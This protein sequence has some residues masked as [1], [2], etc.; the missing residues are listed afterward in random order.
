MDTLRICRQCRAPLPGDAPGMVCPQCEKTPTGIL[1]FQTPPAPEAPPPTA[2]E[3]APFFPQ[4]E[5]IELQGHGGM[6]MV[7]KARQ[8]KLDRLVAIKILAPELSH[9]PAFAERFE[10]EA[11]ALGRL[12]HSNIIAIYDFGRAG[13]FYYFLMEFVD[14]V[15]LYDLIHDK[16]ISLGDTL[17]ITGEI[18]DALQFAHDEGVVHRDIKP[19]NILIDKKGRVKIADFG[20]AKLGGQSGRARS[21]GLQTTFVMG[22]PHYMAPEQ[23]ETPLEVDHRADIYSLGVVVYE[24]LTGEL[25][26]GR[27]AAPSQKTRLDARLDQVVLRALEKEPSRRYQQARQIRT[28]IETVCGPTA[29][30][31]ANSTPANIMS[32]KAVLWRQTALMMAAALLAVFIYKTWRF[33]RPPGAPARGAP[34]RVAGTPPP[35]PELFD[36][37]RDG[38]TLS[39][40]AISSLHLARAQARQ[41]NQIIGD[42]EKEFVDLEQRH[43]EQ[44]TDA[45]GHVHLT[46]KS[47]PQ[48]M[49]NLTD[50]M[51]EHLGLVLA[52]S[53][54]AT[55]RNIHLERLFGNS[56]KNTSAIELWK[57]NGQYHFVDSQDG[58]GDSSKATSRAVSGPSPRIIPKR[59]RMYLREDAAANGQ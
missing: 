56:G 41:V 43:T 52:P 49:R 27:F 17:R 2:G 47:F 5:V 34:A 54:L 44:F 30:M 9:D 58:G 35:A 37:G 38:S 22:T 48:P 59:F 11:K 42:L 21:G 12:N 57:E 24:M 53:Q 33:H 40:H 3:I 18:C 29:V 55:A 4:L 51:W 36:R 28:E 8:P 7:Y 10:R 32:R 14:G 31:A 20:L 39:E 45:A 50:Q 1:A 23:V 26:L 6:G 15:S 13:P 16:Q 19:A 25:P 46:I